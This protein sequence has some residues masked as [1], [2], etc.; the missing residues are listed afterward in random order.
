V[1]PF[2]STDTT[3]TPA[4][5]VAT[6]PAVDETPEVDPTAPDE[7]EA[8]EAGL[9]EVD[10]PE[11]LDDEADELPA[12]SATAGATDKAKAEKTPKAPARAAVPDGYIAPVAFAKVLT[13]H[14]EG[15]G[16]ANKHGLINKDNP[17]A[18]QMVYSYLNQSNKPNSKNPIQ[19][20]VSVADGTVY[21]T[22]EQPEGAVVARE[23][24]LNSD[25]ALAWWDAKDGRVAASKEA[26]KAKADKKAAAAAAAPAA[27]ATPAEP[28]APVTEAE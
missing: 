19:T 17:I 3:E 14:L 20:Y 22:G 2:E 18:P 26:Q 5:V 15:K 28:Q 21:K 25:E 16:S 11:A 27:D 1:N 4:T 24:L 10:T 6:D 9:S 8:A 12:G 23:N 7:D 13:A